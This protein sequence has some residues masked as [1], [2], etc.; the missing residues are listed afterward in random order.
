MT[1]T[2][3]IDK[4]DD[5]DYVL[6]VPIPREFARFESTVSGKDVGGHGKVG[7]MEL[8]FERLGERTV[9]SSHYY[10]SPLQMFQPIY[11]DR[12]RPDMPFVML[13]QNGGG[14]VQ[15]DRYRI[16]I[17]C[18]PD[19]AAHVTTQSHGKL[20]RCEEN[21]IA[22][23]VDITA[24]SGSLIE[25]LPDTTIPYRDSRFFQHVTLRIDPT[26]IA[27]VGDVLAPG[28]SAHKGEHHSYTIYYSQLEATDLAGNL[29][30]ADTIKLE[31]ARHSPNSPAMFGEMDA[32]GVL[33]V[34]TQMIPADQLVRILRSALDE[35][36]STV[37][38]VSTLPN[39]AGVS[40]RMLGSTAYLVEQARTIAWDAAR[41]A[42]F[43]VPA[44]NLRKA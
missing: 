32:L 37:C 13:L 29:L 10:R 40:V 9:R 25:F 41:K 18:G 1:Q 17:S 19:S 21:F 36:D 43:G 6:P 42:L 14:M 31:P 5:P 34:F 2:L 26:A 35:H 38:G 7:L 16:D 39:H 3:V 4:R 28:R 33:Y 11:L 12:H 24:E 23:V 44:P 8:G 20:Y 27:I 22:Q 15:G 30:V